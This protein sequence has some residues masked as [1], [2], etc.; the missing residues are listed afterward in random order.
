M[1]YSL[2]NYSD[3]S[4]VVSVSPQILEINKMRSTSAS[5]ED[6]LISQPSVFKTQ[7]SQMTP[8]IRQMSALVSLACQSA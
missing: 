8:A 3:P 2:R 6:E 7:T 1:V 5:N 4:A